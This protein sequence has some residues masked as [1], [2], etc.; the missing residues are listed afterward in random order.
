LSLTDAEIYELEELYEEREVDKRYQVLRN[1][2]EA[3]SSPNYRV[4]HEAIET[5][6]WVKDKKGV[7]KLESG[8]AGYILEGSSRST[9]TWS[10]IDIIIWLCTE[11]HKDKGCKINIYRE[12]YNEFKET[13]YDDFRQRLDD[14]DLDNKFKRADE[15]KT[16]KIGKSRIAFLG[17]GKHGGTCDY[18]FYN[19]A[20]F[21]K[22]QVF[23]QSEMRCNIFWWMDYNPSFTHHW[24]FDNVQPRHDVG[25]LRTTFKD[26]KFISPTQLNKILSY[27]PWL[28]DS[29]Y[30]ENNV[31]MYDGK[32][33]TEKHQPPPHPVNTENGTRDEFMWKVYGLGLRGAMKG[34]I[35]PLYTRIDKFP[36]IAFTYGLDF[37]FTVDPSALVKYARK[38]RNIYIQPLWYKPTETSEEMHQALR[39]C[40][41]R[42]I[43]PIT[44][45]SADKYVS[46][47]KGVVQMVRELFARGWEIAKVSKTKGIMFWITDMK[48]YK[49]HIVVDL[50]TEHGRAMWKAIKKELENYKMKEVQGILINQPID[51][52]DHLLSAARYAHMAHGQEL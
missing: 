26:N 6:E 32:L 44:A 38:G 19:E 8:Y 37:G 11:R 36:N 31:L 12:T 27:E 48:S 46:E 34:L 13:L 51:G 45:D 14:F 9:K 7:P 16:F 21:I 20:M 15:I 41:V 1:P 24:V 25:F 29:Y 22:R 42:M 4:L 35:Y 33:I 23:D 10:G 40:K 30:I 5:Q 50:S 39:A 47:R 49:I 2:T 43:T 18:A 17:D 52:F 28:P 3:N